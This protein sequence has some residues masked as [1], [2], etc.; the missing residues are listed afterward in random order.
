MSGPL[1]EPV[2]GPGGAGGQDRLLSHSLMRWRVVCFCEPS[3]PH[4]S[5]PRTLLLPLCVCVLLCTCCWGYNKMM[6]S[7]GGR[8][9]TGVLNNAWR[10]VCREN[11]WAMNVCSGGICAWRLLPSLS[12]SPVFT[13][14]CCSSCH[15]IPQHQALNG[16]HS[17][18]FRQTIVALFSFPRSLLFYPYSS[19]VASCKEKEKLILR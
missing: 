12:S 6:G 4:H 11:G 8:R 19:F 18:C 2:E 14:L 7:S 1:E 16:R 3:L 17:D 10:R 13:F 9:K 15:R 5:I